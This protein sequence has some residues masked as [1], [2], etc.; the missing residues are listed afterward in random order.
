MTNNSASE[1]SLSSNSKDNLSTDYSPLG[2]ITQV[3]ILRCLKVNSFVIVLNVCKDLGYFLRFVYFFGL[4]AH[5]CYQLGLL[6]SDAVLAQLACPLNDII[7]LLTPGVNIWNFV[8]SWVKGKQAGYSPINRAL[9]KF[10]SQH[11][12]LQQTFECI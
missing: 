1:N 11:L 2:P 8:N 4:V 9:T 10:P 12:S 7:F 3:K 5:Q 6:L